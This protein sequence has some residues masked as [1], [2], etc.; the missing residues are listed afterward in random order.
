MP[1]YIDV[2]HKPTNSFKHE[3]VFTKKDMD[4]A[5]QDE[6]EAC[7]IECVRVS[8]KCEM[9]Y[10]DTV[11]ARDYG[12]MLGAEICAEAIRARNK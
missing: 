10:L 12:C 1:K 2:Y 3:L 7:L 11:H 8:N 9:N 5:V 6:R 4:K